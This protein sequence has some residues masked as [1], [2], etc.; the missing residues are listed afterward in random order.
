MD[1]SI[2]TIYQ[3]IVK[4]MTIGIILVVAASGYFLIANKILIGYFGKG[5]YILLI[6][7]VLSGIKYCFD[8]YS[9]PIIGDDINDTYIYKSKTKTSYYELDLSDKTS[10]NQCILYTPTSSNDG[11]CIIYINDKR[12]DENLN[13]IL[14][15]RDIVINEGNSFMI[16]GIDTKDVKDAI[17]KIDETIEVLRKEEILSEAILMGE[18]KGG[19][20][21]LL[22]AISDSSSINGVVAL[23]PNVKLDKKIN[24]PV[25][26]I[27]N[28]NSV[29]ISKELSY[30]NLPGD[31][32]E[33][34]DIFISTSIIGDKFEKE[35]KNWIKMD[36]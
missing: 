18:E 11:T 2:N 3:S 15:Y 5:V 7:C 9:I 34:N 12:E 29:N 21:S 31:S 20:V 23:Y 6:L 14:F 32:D 4:Q 16:L 33:F 10:I 19:E 17:K 22:T 27:Q 30:I 8:I 13:S 36:L 26:L 24:I 28:N 25:L 35:F 1:S